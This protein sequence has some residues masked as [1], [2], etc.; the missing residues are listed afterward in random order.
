MSYVRARRSSSKPPRTS[1]IAD[2]GSVRRLVATKLRLL[3]RV[4]IAEIPGRCKGDGIIRR[5][6]VRVSVACR[7]LTS[8][9]RFRLSASA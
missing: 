9:P 7:L 5:H 8:L 4:K 2:A 6:V 3:I 1:A